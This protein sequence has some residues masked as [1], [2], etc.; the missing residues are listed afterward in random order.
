MIPIMNAFVYTARKS[1]MG[2]TKIGPF[3]AGFIRPTLQE[4]PNWTADLESRKNKA[5]FKLET[6][7]DFPIRDWGL[8]RWCCCKNGQK[9]RLWGGKIMVILHRYHLQS[10]SS[11]DVCW[12]EQ[13]REKRQVDLATTNVVSEYDSSWRGRKTRLHNLTKK[14]FPHRG[15]GWSLPSKRLINEND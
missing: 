7:I 1:E 5:N 14:K 15:Q 9:K 6:P 4:L 8:L 11:Q 10:F 12:T 2:P 13:P 3:Q